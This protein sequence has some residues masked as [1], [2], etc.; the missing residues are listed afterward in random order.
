MSRCAGGPRSQV[1]WV[2]GVC[3]LYDFETDTE[4]DRR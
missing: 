3:R 1:G 4:K 2:P